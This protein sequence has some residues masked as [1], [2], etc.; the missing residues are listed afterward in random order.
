MSKPRIVM[1][2]DFFLPGFKGGG[3]LRS[4]V[5][6]ASAL[7]D[8]FDWYVITDDRD[9]LDTQPYDSVPFDVWHPVGAAR[10]MYLSGAGKRL[11]HIARVL[12]ETPHDLLYL[13]SLFSPH[14]TLK[15]LLLRALGRLPRRPVVL[16]PRGELA[17]G[18][19][20]VKP[21]RKQAWLA[22]SRPARLYRELTWHASGP[23]EAALIR[24]WFGDSP[25]IEAPDLPSPLPP[26]RAREPKRPGRLAVGYVSRITSNKNFGF[27]VEAV[28]GLAAEVTLNAYGP[29]EDTGYW[30]ACL[31]R[32]ASLPANVTL[33]AH[34]AIPHARVSE[35]LAAQDVL[36]LPSHAE[37]FGHVIAEALG[38]GCPVLL[39]DRTPW[40]DVER[41]GAGWELPLDQVAPFTAR[42]GQLAAM[43]EPAHAALRT[44]ARAAAEA[45]QRRATAPTRDLFL[46]ALGRAGATPAVRA[47]AAE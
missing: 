20:A 37:S 17:P 33:V 21:A 40:H 16:A 23:D 32:A 28:R 2:C 6:I 39:S 22:L 42:L 9:D 7:A 5:N 38:A 19:L 47:A 36:L 44:R 4:V 15:P 46:T 30:E 45:F 11:G 25:I 14:F 27:A 1:T 26:A 35:V 10:V 12:A 24:R 29:V 3:A 34:G 31:A 43:D 41:D 13:N 8:V 18:C